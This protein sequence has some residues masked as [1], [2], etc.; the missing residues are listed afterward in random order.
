MPITL[1]PANTNIPFIRMRWVG[2]VLSFCFMAATAFMVH[3]NGLNLGIDFTGGILMEIRTPETADLAAMR[4]ALN[5]PELGEVSLQTFGDDKE[6]LIRVE[7]AG[8]EEQGVLV[9]RIQSE[10]NAIIPN[11]EYR[12]TDYVGPTVGKELIESGIIATVLS[13]GAMLL[14]IWF[15]FEWQYG[16]GG[17]LALTHD[18]IMMVGFY[19]FTGYDFGLTSV[20]AILTVIGY[21][22]NDSVVI[23]DRVRENMRK[24]KKMPIEELLNKS[25]NET[26]A[27]TI[28]TGLTTILAALGLGLFGG[29]VIE[30]FAYALVFGVLIGTY[31]SIYISAPVLIYFN[32]RSDR[33]VAEEEQIA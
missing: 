4:Q 8:E 28:V 12:K 10:L 26:L 7:S 20:A 13:M 33:A 19:A 14:Y 16:I 30:G 31:S 18:A 29:P 22:I 25:V 24:Y 9:E 17:I 2:F 15:R 6:V 27:R 3:T 11:I 21:S 23:Y 32:L 5:L 1:I